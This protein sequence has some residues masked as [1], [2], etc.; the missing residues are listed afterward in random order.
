LDT[1]PY[2]KAWA[3]FCMKKILVTKEKQLFSFKS[4]SDICNYLDIKEELFKSVA[5]Y[6]D[7]SYSP[8]LLLKKDKVTYRTINAP[9][10]DLKVI[11]RKILDL[12][13]SKTKLPNYVYGHGPLKSIVH[14]AMTHVKNDCLLNV[15]IKDFFPS[16]HYMKVHKLF[17]ELGFSEEQALLL[18]KLTTLKKCLPQG[19]PTS[20][21]IASL[22]LNNLDNRIN[23]LCKKNRLTYTRYFDDISISGSQ[24]VFE[25]LPT[26]S[27]IVKSE[28]YELHE[29]GDKI[30]MYKFGDPKIITGI[31]ISP[32]KKLSVAGIEKL[33][34]YISILVK[35]GIKSLD[36]DNLEKEKQILY[37]KV[38][39]IRQVDLE[40]GTKL[41][42]L[43][44]SVKW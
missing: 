15:D 29:V 18:T 37:G 9:N 4:L 30:N 3:V 20:P 38:A 25:L 1:P 2:G 7:S 43:L 17:C 11:Q 39:F 22:V 19:A 42:S 8:I 36:T 44:D 40:R 28:G 13:I 14:N 21:Y 33:N 31:T 34:E 23:E 12:I 27:T 26:L 35:Q 41:R 5:H 10:S 32:D 24:R 16:V 6:A